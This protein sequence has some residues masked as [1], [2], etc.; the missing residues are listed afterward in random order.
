MRTKNCEFCTQWQEHC[1]W[2]H[3]PDE[4]KHFF[5]LMVGDFTQSMS[6]PGIFA[7]NFNGYISEY[8]NV[9]SPS[10][11]SWNIG[12]TSDTDEVVLRSGWK[13]FVNHHG[14]GEGDCLLFKYSGAS[15][16]DVLMFDPSGCQKTSPRCV[17]NR[18]CEIAQN[19]A[20]VEQARGCPAFSKTQ[21][22]AP[23]SPPTDCDVAGLQMT[24]HRD[25]EQAHLD[26]N[27]KVDLEMDECEPTAKTGY[28]FCNNGPVSEFHLTEEDK[29]EISSIPVPAEPRNPVF[30]KVIHSTHVSRTTKTS[31]VGVSSEFAAKYLGAVGREI[32]LRRAGSKGRWH[33]SYRSGENYRGFCGRGWRGFTRD[34]SLLAHDICLFELMEGA[35]R[36]AATVHILRK[37]CGRFVLVG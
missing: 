26:V 14:I 31:I 28:Y 11:K 6:I 37:V 24:L 7:K 35:R 29:E 17:K 15:S 18:G 5:K 16:F 27:D 25:T 13:E 20:G 3:M 22:R 21:D 12:V 8:I 19:S 1:Y 10:G 30:V 34:N 4:N 33:V 23:H 32:I 9:K 36:S 2:S